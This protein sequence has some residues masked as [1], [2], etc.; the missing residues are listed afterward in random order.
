[1]KV[2]LASSFDLT[3]E[4]EVVARYLERRGHT[5]AVKWWAQDGFDM[6]DKKADHTSDSFYK[7]EVC[8]IIYE[9]DFKGVAE[10]DALV[11]VAGEAPQKFNGANVEYGI[12]IAF[13]KPCFS[14]GSLLNSAMYYPIRK[15]KRI[16]ELGEALSEYEGKVKT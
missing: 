16:D 2:Y 4:V 9:R 8:Q 15:C 13:G 10:S 1:V 14:I 6:R 3:L 5:I 11:I 7:D 12:A